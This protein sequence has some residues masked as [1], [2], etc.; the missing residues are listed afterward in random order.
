MKLAYLI[1]QIQMLLY[2][3]FPLAQVTVLR[4]AIEIIGDGIGDDDGLCGTNESCIYTPNIG[5]YLDMEI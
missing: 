5:A 3:P 2:I 4:N 1:R